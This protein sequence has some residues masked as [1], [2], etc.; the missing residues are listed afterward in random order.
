MWIDFPLPP[1]QLHSTSLALA[2]T[3]FETCVMCCIN[4]KSL[5]LCQSLIF[6]K[7]K[8][9]ETTRCDI[10]WGLNGFLK[11][12][13]GAWDAGRIWRGAEENNKFSF[14]F[15]ASKLDQQEK[16]I[17]SNIFM[18]FLGRI[19]SRQITCFSRAGSRVSAAPNIVRRDK[20]QWFIIEMANR[21]GIWWRIAAG[22]RLG[23]FIG[24]PL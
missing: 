1:Y 21:R 16:S 20:L 12:I 23:W 3:S 7:K 8:R 5:L 2:S 10:Q 14:G 19:P 11:I 22:G 4:P 24:E 15:G 18:L 9:V 13:S 6:Q 17:S